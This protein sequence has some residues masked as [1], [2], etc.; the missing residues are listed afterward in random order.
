MK[1]PPL[2]VFD[3]DGTLAESK[4]ALTNEM[5]TLLARLL[6]VTRVAIVSGGALPQF[7][8]QVVE[9]LP[10]DAGLAHLYLLPTSGGALY[11]WSGNGWNK[12]Y[13]ERLSEKETRS[14]MSAIDSA[15]AETKVIDL[16][17]P[18]YGDRVEHRGSQ[19][20]L[21]ALG[22]RAPLTLKKEWDIDHT[23][24]QALQAALSERLPDF[25]VSMGGTTSIDITKRN[26]DK[27]YGIR[28]LC[29]RLRVSESDALYIGDELIANG[30]DE[31]VFKTD[32]RVRAVSSPE[33]TAEIIRS[34][35]L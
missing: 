25:S 11:E 34:L 3:L 20:T 30:N 21:S 24:R 14:A 2:V 13:E 23:K 9:H 26:I 4:Q 6:E 22:Q 1:L 32:V 18:A 31:A 28:K 5:A 16:S 17:R 29:E 10:K 15:M 33:E 12:V 19:I 35:V 27:A 7:L 8:K